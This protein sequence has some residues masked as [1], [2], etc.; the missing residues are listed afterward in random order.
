M[1]LAYAQSLGDGVTT[2][3]TV[4]FPYISK[5]HVQ[6]TVDGVAVAY[7]WLSPTSVQITPAPAVDKIVDRRRVTPRDTLLVDFV[8]GSTLVESELDLSALQVFYL[9]QE[10]F[11][12]GES[13]LGVTE[14][15]S[16]SALGRRISN[17]LSPV[18]ANDVATK[19]FVETGVSSGV[20]IA[21]QKA[22]DASS[23]AVAAAA[24]E[25][26]AATSASSAN[27]S[28]NTATTK[29]TEAAT[30]ATNAAT[31]ATTATTKAGEAAASALEAKGYRDT[32]STKAAEA[33]ASAAAAATF[34]PATYYTK[35]EVNTSLGLKLDKTGGQLTGNLNIMK[36]GPSLSLQNTDS[37]GNTWGLISA[38]DGKLYIQKQNGTVVNEVSFGT[39][40]SIWTAQF[41]DLNSRIETRATAWAN[42]RVANLSFRK[43]SP[44]SF[45]VPDNGLQMCPA[46][47]VLTGMNM[48]GTQ[49][50]PTMYYHYLQAYDPVRG[51]V[52]FSGA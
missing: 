2:I 45:S 22:A 32:A 37:G 15:G 43:V 48:A 21:T 30:S 1:A 12:L 46:G 41:G 33:A 38:A 13:S 42:D 27:T 18:E 23:A 4:P 17:V 44:S 6:V 25:T 7:T 10:S 31:S 24:S 11:D 47:A 3:F 51:W 40:G 34:D 19:L 14:D 9:A 8:D 52:T 29:A 16:F 5:T 35:V 20:A 50:N 49:N 28:K 39:D 26:N 36:S